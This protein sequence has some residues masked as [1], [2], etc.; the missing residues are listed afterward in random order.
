[1]ADRRKQPRFQ[2]L[3]LS[4]PFGQVTDI[5]DTGL[6]IFRKGKMDLAVGQ[7]LRLDLRHPAAELTLEAEVMRIERLGLFRHEV[8][9]RFTSVDSAALE[10]IRR[11]V[12]ASQAEMPGPACFLAA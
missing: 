2:T 5:S 4:S 8:G 1:M 7:S 10:A 12:A 9:L 6:R 11:V 3:G